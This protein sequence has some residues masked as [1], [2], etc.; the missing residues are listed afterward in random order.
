MEDAR[1]VDYDERDLL[2]AAPGPASYALPRAPIDEPAWFKGLERKLA[3]HLGR[4]RRLELWIHRALDLVSRPGEE[5]VSFLERCREAAAS[6]ADAEAAKLRDKYRARLDRLRQR[7]GAA[8]ARVRELTVDSQQ[9]VQQEVIAGAGQLLSVFLGG[10]ARL[11]SL[12]G[13]ASRRSTT[14][15][16]QERLDTAKGKATDVADEIERCEAELGEELE[17][18]QRRWEGVAEQIESRAVPLDQGDVTLDQL[19]LVWVPAGG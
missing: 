6:R 15:R 9:R 18:I 13:A 2:S 4:G 8:E 19:T 14:R 16:T 11:G 12:A 10:R 1:T 17:E 5:K 3:E 7:Q